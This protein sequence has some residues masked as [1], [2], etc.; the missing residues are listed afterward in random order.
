MNPALEERSGG[1]ASQRRRKLRVAAR[2]ARELHA[3]GCRIE[4]RIKVAGEDAC[5]SSLILESGDES[6][7]YAAALQ[8]TDN[9]GR[10]GGALQDFAVGD[11][12]DGFLNR[13]MVRLSG[14]ERVSR[15]CKMASQA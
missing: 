15:R 1:A 11:P 5:Q 9:A 7:R 6:V 4:C 12:L 2:G 14:G 3:F 10:L 13:V 8:A